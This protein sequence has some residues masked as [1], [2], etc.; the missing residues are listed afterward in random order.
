ME[1]VD[2]HVLSL[3][4]SHA[5]GTCA[6]TRV[7]LALVCKEWR[8][9]CAVLPGPFERVFVP[10]YP[11][12]DLSLSNHLSWYFK[13]LLDSPT[14]RSVSCIVV[15]TGFTER[16]ALSKD[17]QT[18]VSP[19]VEYSWPGFRGDPRLGALVA[20]LEGDG[21]VVFPHTD[22]AE[23]PSA[24]ERIEKAGYCACCEFFWVTHVKWIEVRGQTVL[25]CNLDTE[26]W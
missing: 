12:D 26:S 14:L 13:I 25:W 7:R 3:I 18:R 20:S 5:I 6:A 2:E 22:A 9:L 16:I 1:T 24:V 21:T 23:L 8:D 17:L 10:N 4:L 11:G 15:R 19:G